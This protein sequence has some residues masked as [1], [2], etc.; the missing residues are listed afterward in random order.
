MPTGVQAKAQTPWKA[1]PSYSMDE[2][3]KPGDVEE[4]A[5][6]PWKAHS[7]DSKDE[8]REPANIEGR[9]LMPW[10]T[11]SSHSKDENPTPVEVGESAEIPSN[12][13]S[14]SSKNEGTL[15][16]SKA[17]PA[18]QGVELSGRSPAS[19]V[20]PLIVRMFAALTRSPNLLRPP[21]DQASDFITSQEGDVPALS[22]RKS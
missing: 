14:S 9:T 3:P 2:S 7:S 4:K 10:M 11:H 22:R 1:Y 13:Y 20:S 15:S 16:E 19:S 6:V 21:T 8:S 17:Q 18:A 5:P 12:A